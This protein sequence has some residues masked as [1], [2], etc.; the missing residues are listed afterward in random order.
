MTNVFG[1][2]QGGPASP[3]GGNTEFERS[4]GRSAETE[5][6]PSS[7]L[8]EQIDEDVGAVKKAAE[9][10]TQRVTDKATEAAERQMGYAAEQIGKFAD[11]LEKVGSEMQSQQPGAVGDYTKRLG[12]SARQFADRFQDKDLG[13]MA[14]IAEDF[15][16]RQ[17]LAFL[18][19]AAIAGLAASRFMMATTPRQSGMQTTSR[20]TDGSGQPAGMKE[21]YNG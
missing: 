7:G 12:A 19:L 15:G 21:T 6:Q 20:T 5:D 4:I 16:R 10:V 18:G 14:A 9:D 3:A 11:A 13:Q 8:R 17:P 2:Q 1:N